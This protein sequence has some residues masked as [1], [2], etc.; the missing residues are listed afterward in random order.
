MIARSV[1]TILIITVS[2][3]FL[4]LAS[5]E[6]RLLI[7]VELTDNQPTLRHIITTS[8]NVYKDILSLEE[9]PCGTPEDLLEITDSLIGKL[10]RLYVYAHHARNAF[11]TEATLTQQEMQF[12]VDLLDQLQC[13]AQAA[14]NCAHFDINKLA[15]DIHTVLTSS[16][17]DVTKKNE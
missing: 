5:Q 3:W 17:K 6:N 4:V 13:T 7:P 14:N 12:L 15:Q 1:F 9:E 11:C 10:I 16:L 8:L 2:C